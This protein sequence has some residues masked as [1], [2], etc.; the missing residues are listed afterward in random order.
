MYRRVEMQIGEVMIVLFSHVN[1]VVD[2]L[3]HSRWIRSNYVVVC[4]RT[5]SRSTSS[6]TVSRLI[7]DMIRSVIRAVS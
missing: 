2:S 7:R 5:I 3:K 6:D 1:L 4:T